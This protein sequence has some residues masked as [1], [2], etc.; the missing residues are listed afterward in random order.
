VKI[1]PGN[2][3]NASSITINKSI[4][5]VGVDNA[6]SPGQDV[7]ITQTAGTHG[8]VIQGSN[9]GAVQISGVKVIGGLDGV[10]IEGSGQVTTLSSLSVTDSTFVGQSVSGMMI[11]LEKKGSDLG[12]LVVNRVVFDQS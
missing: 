5:I 1:A 11:G 3:S 2:Y 10:S 7:V 9:I 12:Q 4:N 6:G 8:F